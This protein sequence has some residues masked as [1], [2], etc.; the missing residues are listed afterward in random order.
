MKQNPFS[1]VT[2]EVFAVDTTDMK[3]EL[4]MCTATRPPVPFAG[5]T[6]TTGRRAGGD[7]VVLIR[8][9]SGLSVVVCPDPDEHPDPR[10]GM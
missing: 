10:V 2:L 9:A 5:F 7:P 8:A 4:S 3:T 1:A 6:V